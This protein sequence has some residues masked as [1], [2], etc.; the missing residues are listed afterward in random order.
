[1]WAEPERS[2]FT[3]RLVGELRSRGF[4]VVV[5]DATGA[6]DPVYLF[7]LGAE[8]QAVAVLALVSSERGVAIWVVDRITDKTV[9]RQLVGSEG[10]DPDV[11]ARRAVEVLR[12]SLL[13]VLVVPPETL[14]EVP[15]SAAR[16]LVGPPPTSADTVGLALYTTLGVRGSWAPDGFDPSLH[17]D[18]TLG[19]RVLPW[20]RI[21]VRGR[22]PTAPN[23]LDRPEGR[24]E[25]LFAGVGAGIELRAATDERTWALWIGAHAE[26]LW[27]QTRGAP[28]PDYLGAV[29]DDWIGIFGVEAVA[30]WRLTP[31]FALYVSAA[32]ELAVPTLRI[33]VGDVRVAT[34]GLPLTSL[35]LGAHFDV[36]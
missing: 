29:V 20:L 11:V 34:W 10:D 12:A 15:P 33:A 31:S 16:D 13:E 30:E 9:M 22:V 21:A 36:L 14:A 24:I 6:P 28:A 17:I 1:M 2:P 23:Y 8:L 35:C 4:E 27:A 19:L 18:L 5:R 3:R 32:I 26:A 25:L 7:A